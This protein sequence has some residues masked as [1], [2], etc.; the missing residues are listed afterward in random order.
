MALP[1]AVKAYFLLSTA[2]VSKENEK[3]AG[4][5]CGVLNY[6]YMKDIAMEISGDP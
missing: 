3:L 4:T 2:N 1:E 6:K 5:T